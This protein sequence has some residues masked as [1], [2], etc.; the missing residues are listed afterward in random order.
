M[1]YLV[2][3]RK[4][5]INF[6]WFAIVW[7]GWFFV[8]WGVFF[9]FFYP[10]EWLFQKIA[11]LVSFEVL[12]GVNLFFLMKVVATL[13]E[14]VSE[15]PISQ[16]I[17]ST[18]RRILLWGFLKMASLSLL[19]WMLLLGGRYEGPILGFA[20][21]TVLVIPLFWVFAQMVLDR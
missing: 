6:K 14:F 3:K 15:T 9:F 1:S 18:R 4:L 5:A 10:K 19:V 2:G 12:A 7:I 11:W 21:A 20:V 8:S 16:R 13:M 17:Q